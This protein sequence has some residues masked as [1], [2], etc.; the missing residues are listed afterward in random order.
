M[1]GDAVKYF[2]FL[3]L[4]SLAALEFFYHFSDGHALE[5]VICMEPGA[6]L[7]NFGDML[8]LHSHGH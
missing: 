3:V 2:L 6:R 1:A 4:A 5:S 8:R 7:Q